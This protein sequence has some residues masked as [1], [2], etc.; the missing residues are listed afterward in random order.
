MI[1]LIMRKAVSSL[2]LVIT[3]LAVLTVI[4]IWAGSYI[5]DG[6][7]DETNV[8]GDVS[9]CDT[10]CKS[11]NYQYGVCRDDEFGGC[12]SDELDLGLGENACTDSHCCCVTGCDFACKDD[13]YESGTCRF[14]SWECLEGE[15]NLGMDVCKSGWPTTAFTSCCCK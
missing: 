3:I 7:T 13:G 12:V 4:G 2:I 11:M 15:T 1:D 5:L 9:D 10:V 8:T 6:Q 14:G